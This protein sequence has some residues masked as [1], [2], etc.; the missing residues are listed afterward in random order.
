MSDPDDNGHYS[1][2]E[3]VSLLGEDHPDVTISKIRFL[4]SQGLIEPER[5]PSGYR[6]FYKPDIE[7]LDWILIQQR[8]NQ[9]PLK[10]IRQK[11][12]ALEPGPAAEPAVLTAPQ[13]DGAA[14][15]AS[16]SSPS[17]SSQLVEGSVSLTANELSVAANADLGLIRGLVRFG[18]I[19][20]YDTADG[21]IFDHEALKLARAAAA[22]AERGVEPR[23]LRMF[24]VA[25]EREAGLYE[26]IL[27]PRVLRGQITEASV[28][29]SE[30]VSLAET[31]RQTLLRRILGLRLG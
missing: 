19:E 8:D 9:L 25:A 22:F 21:T 14:S 20:G 30:L 16:G 5:T 26:Q 6:K 13:E 24:K 4:E 29:L 15:D 1:I 17:D 11:L 2:G 27:V 7:R 18:L 10:M 31:M 3:V 28:E 12:Q 23:H